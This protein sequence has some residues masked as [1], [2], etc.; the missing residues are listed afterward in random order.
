MIVLWLHQ[1]AQQHLPQLQAGH[2]VA[3]PPKDDVGAPARHVGGDGH[4]SSTTGLSH[5]LRFPFHVLRLGVEQV[6][7][8]LL[9]SQQ[10]AQQLAFLH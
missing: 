2:V 3:V 5:D 10:G 6:V 8:N 9:L 4:R 7:G 1:T